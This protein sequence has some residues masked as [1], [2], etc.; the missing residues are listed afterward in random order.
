MIEH[1]DNLL[2]DLFLAQVPGIADAAQV[3]FE[4]PDEDWRTWVLN[5]AAGA[6]ALNIYLADLR[7]NRS[8]RSN[9]RV[10]SFEN[11]H[12]SEESAPTRLDCHYLITAWSQAA[13][14]AAVEP[15]L[16]EHRV[17]HDALAVLFNQ[18]PLNPS[19]I[20]PPGSA[21]LTAVPEMIRRADL[22][23]QIAPA[24]GFPKLPE[25]W[26]AMGQNHRWKPAIYLIV[27]LPVALTPRIEGPMV[28]TRIAEHRL[29]GSPESAEIMIQIG[30]H[31]FNASVD[32]VEM[33]PEAWVRLE[34][35]AGEPLQITK[36]DDSGRFTFLRM[37]PG[38]YRLRVRATGLG[39]LERSV[40]V[41]SELGGYD[42]RFP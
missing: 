41:P 36:T 7:E 26:G 17:L 11:G 10:R 29:F 6:V 1:L 34:D 5:L 3:R 22:P 12:V 27:T 39:E 24:E 2:R 9:E 20:H 33:V 25:F 40:N 4:P 28:T 42:I 18:A 14:A 31:V 13:P 32:P 37:H 38:N 23:T 19:R 8:L 15:P 30:G 21:A 35:A 16:D